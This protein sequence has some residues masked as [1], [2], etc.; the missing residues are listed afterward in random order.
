[1]VKDN[2]VIISRA[3]DEAELSLCTADF[4]VARLEQDII[5]AVK[6]PERISRLIGRSLLIIVRQSE[7]QC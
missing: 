2:G 5:L 1:M 6:I 4:T 7:K 3:T